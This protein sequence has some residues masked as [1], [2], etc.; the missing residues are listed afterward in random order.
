MGY[1]I[2]WLAVRGKE[3][4]EILS[5]LGL[6]HT[7]RMAEYGEAMYTG[8][9]LPSG[10]F[11]LV[12]NRCEHEF[13][14][15]GSL[16]KLSMEAEV[17]ACS[18]E[19]HVMVST[20]ELWKDGSNVWRIEHDVQES[21]DHLSESGALPSSYREIK[22]ALIRDQE[23]AGG[24]EADVDFFFEIPLATAKDIVGF[25][26]DEHSGLEEN[27]FEVFERRAATPKSWWKLWK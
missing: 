14:K 17:V 20:S 18:I 12:L 6:E 10:W 13:V 27:S 2:S 21:S 23:A 1:S 16:S 4:P 25:K 7:G 11:L 26:H 24:K 3:P 9:M 15:P 22:N 8:R 5:S 19:E